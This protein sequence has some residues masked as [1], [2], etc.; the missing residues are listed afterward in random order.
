MVP[1]S[2]ISGDIVL[3]LT[4]ITYSNSQ[5]LIYI[6]QPVQENNTMGGIQITTTTPVIEEGK[7]WFGQNNQN[8]KHNTKKHTRRYY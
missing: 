3:I 2:T 4:S 8:Q 7:D 6:K 1:P 5:T